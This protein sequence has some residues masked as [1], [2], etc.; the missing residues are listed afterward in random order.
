MT[1]DL[2]WLSNY[3]DSQSNV[4]PNCG[5]LDWMVLYP[6]HNSN[7]KHRIILWHNMFWRR[8]E[9]NMIITKFCIKDVARLKNSATIVLKSYVV[10]VKEAR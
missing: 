2:L 9:K 1:P 7:C 6:V 10:V 4:S 5:N 8:N 3:N